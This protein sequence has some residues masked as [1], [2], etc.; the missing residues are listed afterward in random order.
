MP[1]PWKSLPISVVRKKL[2][3]T[4]VTRLAESRSMALCTAPN[5]SFSGASISPTGSRPASR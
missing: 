2:R 5:F 4:K 1:C 3:S